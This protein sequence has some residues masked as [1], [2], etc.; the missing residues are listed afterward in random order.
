MIYFVLSGT[1][2]VNS[3]NQYLPCPFPAVTALLSVCGYTPLLLIGNFSLAVIFLQACN[4]SPYKAARLS[5]FTV[6]F[7]FF[8]CLVTS[9]H[10]L[11]LVI[12]ASSHKLTFSSRNLN[13]YL[14]NGFSFS[15]YVDNH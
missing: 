12:Y 4:I 13:T 2:N 14:G 3:T 6:L 10:N 9:L 1:L 8:L 11:D 15:P 7:V 5:G